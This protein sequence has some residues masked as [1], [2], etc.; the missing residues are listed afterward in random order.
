MSPRQTASSRPSTSYPEPPTSDEL[1]VALPRGARFGICLSHDIDHLGL[2]EHLVDGFL[3]RYAVNILRQNLFGRF[4]PARALDAYWGIVQAAFG[5]DRWDVLEPLLEAEQRA[6]VRSTWFVA[7]RRGLGIAYAPDRAAA[8]IRWLREADQDVALHGQSPRDASELAREA[9][10]L[11]ALTGQPVLGLRMHY[12]RLSSAVLDGMERAGLR[13]DSSVME[14]SHLEPDRHA[15]PGPRRIRENLLEIPLHVMD[16]TLFSVTGLGLD[17][18][19]AREYLRRLIDN[20]A[21]RG[22]VITV[23][24]H[25]NSYS[26]Q[27]RDCRDWYDALLGELT[28]RSDAF[29]TDFRG[30]LDRIEV[31]VR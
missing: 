18:D 30:L 6:G 10:D 21:E 15:L 17:L 14:R 3:A 12:L 26:S 22:R 31:P 16:A 7:M 8:A 4:R 20:A 19:D 24:L 25:P 29:V 1:R 11:A 28:R 9:T 5:R 2:R 23:N 27:D 13:Y